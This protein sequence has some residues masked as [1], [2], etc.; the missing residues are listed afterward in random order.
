MW[1]QKQYAIGDEVVGR[2]G[3]ST[4]HTAIDVK[5]GARYAILRATLYGVDQATFLLPDTLSERTVQVGFELTPTGK[6]PRSNSVFR[7][8]IADEVVFNGLPFGKPDHFKLSDF[9]ALPTIPSELVA[10]SRGQGTPSGLARWFRQVTSS[11]P[12][13]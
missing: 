10:V 3:R 7:A 5:T 4:G 13:L 8:T 1:W 9:E 11:V 2:L 6:V 12:A